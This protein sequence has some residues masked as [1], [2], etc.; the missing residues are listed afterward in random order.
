MFSRVIKINCTYSSGCKPKNIFFPE[1]MF[2]QQ[3]LGSPL[4]WT[5]SW[6]LVL[7]FDS[8]SYLLL[9]ALQGALKHHFFV[10]TADSFHPSWACVSPLTWEERFFLTWS[11]LPGTQPL[12]LL[13]AGSWWESPSPHL[14]TTKTFCILK[15]SLIISP[16]S[17]RYSIPL[18]L[19]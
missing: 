10:N 9:L 17:L 18:E 16:F 1:W 3:S 13:L 12:M 19:I 15:P 7:I 5:A 11:R 14:K 8:V 2:T 6:N 4:L